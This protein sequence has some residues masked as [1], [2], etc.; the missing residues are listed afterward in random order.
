MKSLG[1]L[2]HRNR[3]FVS[4][5]AMDVC[6]H[7]VFVV[8][9][10]GSGLTTSWSPVQGDLPC[11]YEIYISELL[12]NGH[13][14]KS[15]IRQDRRRMRPNS[16]ILIMTSSPSPLNCSFIWGHSVSILWSRYN[17]RRVM[18]LFLA[19]ETTNYALFHTARR[20]LPTRNDGVTCCGDL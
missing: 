8:S 12:L 14:S 17:G 19:I 18:H 10:I 2:K 20:Y 5:L 4:S 1:P 3:G 16:I 9:C 15:L 6:V 13:R 7:P 11:V